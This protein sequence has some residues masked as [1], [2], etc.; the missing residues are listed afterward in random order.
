MTHARRWTIQSALTLM[1]S[2]LAT[3]IAGLAPAPVQAKPTRLPGVQ[4]VGSVI[5]GAPISVVVQDDLGMEVYYNEA[6]QFYGDDSGGT[7]LKINGLVY[8]KT[9]LAT[10][11]FAPLDFTPISNNGPTGSG[12]RE[13]PFKAVTIVEAGSTGVRLTQTTRYVNGNSFYDV[14]IVVNNTTDSPQTVTIFHGADLYLNFP[15]NLLDF[16]YGFYDADSGAVG[17]ISEDNQS[18]Q[19]FIPVTPAD[20]FQESFYGIFWRQ[21]GGPGGVAGDGLD[22][23]INRAYHDTAAGLE[24]S[25]RV[26]AGS[27]AAVSLQGAFGKIGEI[28]DEP[29]DPAKLPA[30]VTVV[31]RP[32]PNTLV[33]RGGIVTYNIVVTNRGK[34][35]AKNVTITVP[36]DPTE[37]TVLDAVFTGSRTAWVSE[38]RRNGL[39]IRT[40]AIAG[41][42]TTITATLRMRVNDEVV[43]EADLGE[44]IGFEWTDDRDGGVSASNAT[45]V[46]VGDRPLNLPTYVF[47]VT[48]PSGLLSQ[49]R[50]FST[51]IFAPGEPVALWINTPTGENLPIY[52]IDGD[53]QLN[54][55]GDGSIAV[56]LALSDLAPGTYSIVTYGTWTQFTA[57][58]A[59]VIQ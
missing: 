41:D 54:A 36:F 18:I 23:T 53:D 13:D 7:F 56:D 2:V 32:T 6:Q 24:Y 55:E 34:G 12:T 22:N 37:V 3:S 40:G 29:V 15:D 19:V 1:L 48:P 9:P 43:N 47:A 38:L 50:S 21:I 45:L 20:A 5:V 8:G 28:I 51:S 46:S 4:Q 39:T 30:L 35:Q 27:S 31:N 58:G 10:N 33:T 14:D 17:A 57:T 49:V 44:R 11:G 42:S 59:V 26:A 25:R 52:E 16:G